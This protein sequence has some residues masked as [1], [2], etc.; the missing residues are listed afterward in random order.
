MMKHPLRLQLDRV[1]FD[2]SWS[3]VVDSVLGGVVSDGYLKGEWN[4][5][6]TY[7]FYSLSSDLAS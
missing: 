4:T 3:G 1:P 5:D 6:E 2:S 7:L